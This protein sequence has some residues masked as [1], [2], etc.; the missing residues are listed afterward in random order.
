MRLARLAAMNAKIRL[1]I[2]EAYEVHRA[3]IAWNSSTS[4]DRMPDASLG[5]DPLTLAVMRRA[6]VSWERV[7]FL[8]RYAAGTLAPRLSLDLLPG[9]RCSA[10][11]ALIAP[12]EP[13]NIVDRVNAGRAVQQLWLTATKLGLQMQPSYTPLVF[14]RYFREGRR[15]TTSADAYPTAAKVNAR[16]NQLLGQERAV[17]TV[18]LGRIGPARNVVGRSLRLPMEQL[19]Y[20]PISE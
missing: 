16:L 12:K 10:H 15:F 20:Q 2:R 18:F 17:R 9:V 7:H 11:F 6:M 8:N 19:M 1:T 5:A 3:V 14:A 4:D 13:L